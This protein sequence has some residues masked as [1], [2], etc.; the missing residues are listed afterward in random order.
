MAHLLDVR[1]DAMKLTLCPHTLKITPTDTVTLIYRGQITGWQGFVRVDGTTYTWMGAAPGPST[2]T[3]T[4]FE[5]T[6]TSSI[7]TFD[8]AGKITMTV[9]F[10]SPVYPNDLVKQSLQ[11]SYVDIAVKSSDGKQ[12]STQVYMDISGGESLPLRKH[13]L[14]SNLTG[15]D[16]PTP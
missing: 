1:D 12:H 4:S 2:V 8:V 11:F 3:Q 10:L 13:R 14:S 9:T 16:I 6:S 5:Y 15:G 7:F